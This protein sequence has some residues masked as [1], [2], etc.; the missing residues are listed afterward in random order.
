MTKG[1]NYGRITWAYDDFDPKVP[2]R[3]A[4]LLTFTPVRINGKL[5]HPAFTDRT[6]LE[7]FR[8]KTAET[9]PFKDAYKKWYLES[10]W[11]D[12][13]LG[14]GRAFLRWL[15]RHET[16]IKWKKEDFRLHSYFSYEDSPKHDPDDEMAKGLSFAIRPVEVD[17]RNVKLYLMD[18][19]VI[20]LMSLPYGDDHDFL[21][22]VKHYV[23]MR[24]NWEKWKAPAPTFLDWVKAQAKRPVFMQGQIGFN[25]V[26]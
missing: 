10:S 23:A 7:L 9:L 21:D 6:A 13:D 4:P 12:R 24:F 3:P 5:K 8:F 14:E 22:L 15:Y 1:L 19:A 17:R 18:D 20:N 2:C 26:F 16:S 11:I 25:P